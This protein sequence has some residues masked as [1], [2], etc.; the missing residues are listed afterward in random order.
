MAIHL[1]AHL[2]LTVTRLLRGMRG[3]FS[4]SGTDPGPR[5]CH[6]IIAWASIVARAMSTLQSSC[7]QA[8]SWLACRA[9]KS[10][11][12]LLTIGIAAAGSVAE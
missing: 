1:L 11:S 7:L 9:R 6:S 3:P 10:V 2:P 4:T 12:P 8:A 5:L